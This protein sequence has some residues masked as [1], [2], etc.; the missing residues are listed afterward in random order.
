M[1][2]DFNAP[3]LARDIENPPSDDIDALPFGWIRRAAS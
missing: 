1:P 2:P 3:H